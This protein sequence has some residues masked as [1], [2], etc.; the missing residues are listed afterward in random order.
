MIGWFILG[1][2]IAWVLLAEW[3][4]VRLVRAAKHHEHVLRLTLETLS[5][6]CPHPMLAHQFALMVLNEAPWDSRSRFLGSPL[7][8][9]STQAPGVEQEKA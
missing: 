1:L 2:V 3:R 7:V 8:T 6:S 5:A 4:I 9:K